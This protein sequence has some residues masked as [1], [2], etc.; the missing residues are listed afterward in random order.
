MQI[1]RCSRALGFVLRRNVNQFRGKR[2]TEFEE[3]F[4]RNQAMTYQYSSEMEAILAMAIND[5][6]AFSQL[7]ANKRL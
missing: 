7:P 6:D 4:L 5:P 2:I 1:V 3:Q